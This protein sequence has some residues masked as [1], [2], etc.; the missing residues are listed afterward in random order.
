MRE[1]AVQRV[2]PPWPLDEFLSK[3]G[4][5]VSKYDDR[6]QYA[7][8]YFRQPVTLEV[9]GGLPSIPRENDSIPT[10]CCDISRGG[11][12]FLSPIELYPRETAILWLGNLGKKNVRI[13]RCRRLAAN[14]YEVGGT[15]M[16]REPWT[17]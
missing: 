3:Q 9:T 7:R 12:A 11:I 17:S 4:I 5:T 1:Q 8:L 16:E 13:A 14:C 10:Y 15:F 2:L 6:R